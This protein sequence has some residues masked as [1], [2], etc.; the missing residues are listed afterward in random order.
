MTGAWQLDRKTPILGLW[1]GG[2]GGAEISKRRVRVYNP[3]DEALHL[4]TLGPDRP[5]EFRLVE[6][7]TP[8]NIILTWSNASY[9]RT[10]CG[11]D[12]APCHNAPEP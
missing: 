7:S 3:R 2:E 6:A 1:G 5:V 4:G 11:R 12:T 10:M 8:G 9:I